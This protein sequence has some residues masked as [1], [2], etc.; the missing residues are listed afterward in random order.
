MAPPP[1]DSAVG[2]DSHANASEFQDIPA[3]R[4][5]R[6]SQ[7]RAAW[8]ELG[9]HYP[10]WM[11]LFLAVSMLNNALANLGSPRWDLAWPIVFPLALFMAFYTLRAQGRVD[12]VLRAL[13]AAL[14]LPILLMFVYRPSPLTQPELLRV[15]EASNFIVFLPLLAYAWRHGRGTLGVFFGAG[16]LYGVILENGGIAMGYFAE[17]SYRVYVPGLVAPVATMLG[18]VMVIYLCA[19]LVWQARRAFPRLQR[20]AVWSGLLFAA[21]GVLFDLQIDPVATATRCWTWDARLPAF[22]LGVPLVNYVAWTAALWPFGTALFAV[23]Q[24]FAI[25]DG[26]DWPRKAQWTLVFAVPVA[27]V[28]ATVLFFG[29]MTLLEGG[30][31]GP[32]WAVFGE[33]LQIWLPW[34]V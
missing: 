21:C 25:A 28:A 13:V 18:W 4:P 2:L 34:L 31:G 24:H 3:Q 26:A 1:P 14:A 23:Q 17:M 22:W 33:F 7:V 20:S 19:F 9:V 11:L 30:L 32:T 6:P 8:R 12:V 15:Y 10:A 16:L 29:T 5:R 27:L